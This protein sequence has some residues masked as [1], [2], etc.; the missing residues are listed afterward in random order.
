MKTTPHHVCIAILT[1][2][3]LL[4]CNNLGD[5]QCKYDNDCENDYLCQQNSCIHISSLCTKDKTFCS[6]NCVDIK[7]NPLHC[8]QCGFKCPDSTICIWGLCKRFC[9]EGT[10]ECEEG[11]CFDILSD[12]SNCGGCERVCPSDSICSSGECSCPKTNTY[13][14]LACISTQTNSNHCGKCNNRCRKTEVCRNG[15]CGCKEGQKW[16]HHGCEDIL[17]SVLNCGDCM[18]SCRPP[19]NCVKGVC[20]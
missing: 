15:I 14:G 16:C 18:R 6:D 5:S 12:S 20:K 19:K 9:P 8:G 10:K 17:N 4:S 7:T 3:V 13:C 2:F 11:Q 1:V